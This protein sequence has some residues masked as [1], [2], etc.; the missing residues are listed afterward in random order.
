VKKKGSQKID[1]FLFFVSC[2]HEDEDIDTEREAL[3]KEFP[4]TMKVFE[5]QIIQTF[6]KFEQMK[7]MIDFQN[8]MVDDILNLFVEDYIDTLVVDALGID[9]LTSFFAQCF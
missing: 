8:D 7:R 4:H 9:N 6:N 2:E 3:R 5:N 1:C